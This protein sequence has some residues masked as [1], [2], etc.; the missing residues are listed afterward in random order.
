MQRYLPPGLLGLG[1][2]ALVVAAMST[3][4]GI[5][6]AIAG[7]ISADIFRFFGPTT[8]SDKRHL[9]LTRLFA[10]LS[11]VCG[12]LFAMFIPRFGRM[13]PFYV[14]IWLA[15]PSDR[16]EKYGFLNRGN[17][18]VTDAPEH[19]VVGPDGKLILA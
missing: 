9:R 8:A 12:T 16:V 4:A 1:V 18:C 14:N 13:I 11:I 7:L 6:T 19:R 17:Q 15:Q 5:G 10:C 2:A 3:G